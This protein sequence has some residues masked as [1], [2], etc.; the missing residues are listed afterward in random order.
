MRWFSSK[1]GFLSLVPNGG[2]SVEPVLRR[3]DF[4]AVMVLLGRGQEGSPAEVVC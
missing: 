4:I 2:G 3:K 1:P